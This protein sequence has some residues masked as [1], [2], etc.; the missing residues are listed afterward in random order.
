MRSPTLFLCLIGSNWGIRIHTHWIMIHVG[1]IIKDYVDNNTNLTV[2][3]FARLLNCD[4]TNIYKIYSRPSIDT[5]LLL[6][7][8]EVLSHDFFKDISELIDNE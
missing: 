5:D 6:R 7:I 3:A 1:Q 4:R 8:N 2:V